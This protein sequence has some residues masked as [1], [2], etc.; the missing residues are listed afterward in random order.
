MNIKWDKRMKDS[1][2]IK[3]IRL[4]YPEVA[5]LS[6]NEL[7]DNFK[8]VNNALQVRFDYHSVDYLTNLQFCSERGWSGW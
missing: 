6:D 4:N 3:K 7:V 8:P 5:H 1:N 2:A